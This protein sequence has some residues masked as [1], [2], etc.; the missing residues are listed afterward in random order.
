MKN[1][2]KLREWVTPMTTGAFA[3]SAITGIMLFFNV[4]LG[5]VKHAHEWLSWLLV[6]G[7]IFHVIVNRHVLVKYLS[8]P[9]GK[10]I[11]VVFLALIG[12][13]VLPNGHDPGMHPLARVNETI[14]Q[15]PLSSVALVANH[16]PEEA[17]NMLNLKGIY[18]ERLDQTII[19]IARSNRMSPVRV[20]D[21]IF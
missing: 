18:V 12:A 14:I 1:E 21:A 11:L 4:Q 7:A 5:F 3:L 10:V 19:E 9:M 13:S 2:I 8:K 20:L 6:I 16:E 15:S 17:V